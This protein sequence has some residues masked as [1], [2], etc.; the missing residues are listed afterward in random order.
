MASLSL[1]EFTEA[2]EVFESYDAEPAG[3][4][5]DLSMTR[6]IVKIFGSG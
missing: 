4:C 6:Q 1:Q 3:L 2:V 5:S